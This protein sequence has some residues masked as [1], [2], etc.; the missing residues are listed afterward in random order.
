V[1][2]LLLT[3]KQRLW[4]AIGFIIAIL[5]AFTAKKYLTEKPQ[6]RNQAIPVTVVSVHQQDVSVNLQAVGNVTPYA[7]VSVKSQADGPLLSVGFKPG[8]TIK[9]GDLLFTIDP[10]PYQVALQQAEANLARDN[11]LL[12]NAE[13]EVARSKRL[14]A[15]KFTTEENYH[16]VNSNKL[17]QAATVQADVAVVEHAKLQ[18]SYST[19]YS[20]I[21]GVAGNLLVDVGNLVKA[22]DTQPLV[23]INQISP[24]YVS[25]ATAEKNLPAIRKRL[26]L[27]KVMVKAINVDGN[28]IAEQGKLF[29]IDNT[30][31]TVTG[32]VLLKAHFG[33]EQHDLWPGQYVNVDLSLYDVPDAL[34]I[35]TR[36]IQQGQKG[37][38]VFV[39]TA[40]NKAQYRT[41]EPGVAVGDDTIV[42]NGLAADEKVVVDGQF[43]LVDGS[44][45]NPK[46]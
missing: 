19:I 26:M 4:F 42:V 27:G 31:D 5:L 37:H 21:N 41:I 43:R 28:P 22:N 18:L 34:L 14:L 16:Q 32:T 39:I 20:L 35:P 38:Y 33:N 46:S 3:N 45:V 23:V 7:T 25:F 10:R 12:A 11:A 1:K 2:S 13:M 44:I 9:K 29:F 6:D 15:K 30:I 24:I 17:A 40:D 36:A 8:D